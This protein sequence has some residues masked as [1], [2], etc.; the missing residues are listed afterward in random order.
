MSLAARLAKAAITGGGLRLS[1]TELRALLERCPDLKREGVEE[2][3]ARELEAD[4]KK[5]KATV[6]AAGAAGTATTGDDD[7][8]W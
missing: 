2:L 1:I 6:R 3:R 4:A 7:E 8:I 5:G